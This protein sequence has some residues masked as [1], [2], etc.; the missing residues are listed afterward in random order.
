MLNPE[1]M[2]KNSRRRKRKELAKELLKLLSKVQQTTKPQ[3]HEIAQIIPSDQT[4]TERRAWKCLLKHPLVG[5]GNRLWKFLWLVIVSLSVVG[6]L[7][8]Y[9]D[10]HPKISIEPSTS[11]DEQEPLKMRFIIKNM[12]IIPIYN[13]HGT[14]F[15]TFQE[16]TV[17]NHALVIDFKTKAISPLMAY[18]NGNSD[19][20]IP[21]KI[22]NDGEYD[23]SLKFP[24]RYI[25]LQGG[26]HYE[27]YRGTNNIEFQISCFY[28]P[29]FWRKPKHEIFRFLAI[30]DRQN[31][32]KW[33]H[34]G[35]GN[36]W[37]PT[38]FPK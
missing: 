37:N 7:G 15:W 38:N 32:F 2:S 28:K 27:A 16:P 5:W 33:L 14:A 26:K 10:R 19:F 1:S 35:S 31:N 34:E 25:D 13:V 8:V 22:D 21:D 11:I 36:F 30:P 3:E 20:S 9:I 12:G 24:D 6:G 23:F 17:N 18:Y 4:Q 29:L